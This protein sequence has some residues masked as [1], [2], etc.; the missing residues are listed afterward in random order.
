MERDPRPSRVRRELLFAVAA[1]ARKA[2]QPD[3]VITLGDVWVLDR[4][5]LRELPVAHW[6]PGDC[7]PMSTADAA[8]VEAGG[9]G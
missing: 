9:R 3:L 8:V 7:R 5:L 6:L 4:N 2:V 1:A